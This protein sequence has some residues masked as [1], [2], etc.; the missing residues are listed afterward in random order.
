MCV[1]V[2]VCD[3]TIGMQVSKCMCVS[4]VPER[5]DGAAFCGHVI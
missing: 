2:C 1:C 4:Y 5:I 3:K